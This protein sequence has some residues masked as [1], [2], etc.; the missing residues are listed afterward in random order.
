MSTDF[1]PCFASLLTTLLVACGSAAQGAD[2]PEISTPFFAKPYLQLGDHAQLA[3]LEAEELLWLSKENKHWAVDLK[4][5]ESQI[6][7]EV[8]NAIHHHPLLDSQQPKLEI[9]S[10][11]LNGLKPGQLF[12][13]RVRIDKQEVFQATSMARKTAEQPLHIAIFGDCA[14]GTD[15]QKKIAYQCSKQNP[16]LIVVPGDIVY[17]RGL[18]SEYASRFFPVYNADHADPKVG[19]PIT[20]SH[21]L[22]PVLGNHDIAFVNDTNSTDL[23]R[24]PDALAYFTVW[25]QPHNGPITKIGAKGAP[26]LSGIKSNK[27]AFLQ[28]AGVNYP[29]MANYSF[30]YGNSHWT[31]LDGNYYMDWT[32]SA[33]RDWVRKDVNAAKTARWKFVTFHQPGFSD[34]T[35][36]SM[37]QRMR[38]LSD[39]FEE[40]GVDVVWAGHVHNYQRTYPLFF[41][42]A[43]KDGK[44]VM[45]AD[46]T[47]TGTFRLD[48]AY[49][50]KSVTKPKG[51]IYVITGAGGAHL[52]GVKQ[53]TEKVDFIDKFNGEVHSFTTCDIN[54]DTMDVRQLNDEGVPLDEFK[55]TKK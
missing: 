27:K 49:N 34:D 45:N 43:R 33:L 20:R 30:D 11:E 44:P 36:H 50:G 54:G 53:Q 32:D 51:V 48:K 21:L 55:L 10:C 9:Y 6:W 25:S 14:S 5:H 2:H 52:Y 4:P 29:V 16:D 23:N 26:P 13:Y 15:A 28:S 8:K 12:D 19:A 1:K 3:P 37:E 18:F 46:G 41:K 7:T 17:N 39:I 31:V 40:C 22:A 38:L 35:Q 24:F 42:A 47:V